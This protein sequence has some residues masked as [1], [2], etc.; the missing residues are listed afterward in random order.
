MKTLLLLFIQI[1]FSFSLFAEINVNYKG[2]QVEIEWSTSTNAKIDYFIIERSKN[3]KY[4][5][6]IRKIKSGEPNTNY[7]EVDYHPPKKISFYRIKQVKSDGS[8][9]Y[10]ATILVKRYTNA[11]YKKL[12]GY[13]QNDV[14][15]VLKDKNGNEV[16]TKA[17]IT[18]NHK[19]LFAVADNS[20]IKPA[21][22]TIISSSD[23]ILLNKQVKIINDDAMVDAW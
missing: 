14:L 3:G 22:Y 2:K 19:Q 13:H 12:K 5:K 1:L 20:S 11:K 23:D 6:A 21:F 7:Y 9:T 18:E 10:S 17:N 16:Y 8:F 4:F 15:L